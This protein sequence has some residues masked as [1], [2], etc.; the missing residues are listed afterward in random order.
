MLP[1]LSPAVSYHLVGDIY[2]CL[3]KKDPFHDLAFLG[4]NL[5]SSLAIAKCPSPLPLHVLQDIGT[6]VQAASSAWRATLQCGK[7]FADL[8]ITLI[9]SAQ[10]L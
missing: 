7:A 6:F 2:L 9:A 5:Y 1:K 8:E 4:F 3:A 10:T